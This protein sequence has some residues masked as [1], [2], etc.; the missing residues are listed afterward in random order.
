MCPFKTV[1]G[2]DSLPLLRLVDETLRV[3][4]VNVM[5]RERNEVLDKLKENLTRAK[6]E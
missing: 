2:R 1:Y 6:K 4:K 5:I 3:E